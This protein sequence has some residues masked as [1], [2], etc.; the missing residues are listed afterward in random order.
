MTP[1]FKHL[2]DKP[3][4][5]PF[6]IGQWAIVSSGLII[7]M[8]LATSVFPKF[9]LH[10]TIAFAFAVYVGGIPVGIVM[11]SS[12]LE[13]NLTQMAVYWWRWRRE[14]PAVYVAGPG[15]DSD[16]YVLIAEAQDERDAERARTDFN[17][18]LLWG[19]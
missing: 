12:Y 17:P 1:A 5:G 11:L 3:K 16:G 8:V 9:G 7:I 19:V 4:M 6:T 10:G 18:E 15:A 13:L 14:L 2:E